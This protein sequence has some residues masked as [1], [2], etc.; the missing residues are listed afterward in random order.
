M[1]N[2][3]RICEYFFSKYKRQSQFKSLFKLLFYSQL[4][5]YIPCKYCPCISYLPPE[6]NI[7]LGSA[8]NPSSAMLSQISDCIV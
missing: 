4:K 8:S 2:R 7:V 5:Y 3:Y 6:T 1:P